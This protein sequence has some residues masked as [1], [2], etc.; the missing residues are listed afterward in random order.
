[1]LNDIIPIIDSIPHQVYV[2]PFGGSGVVILNKA[3]INGIEVLNDIDDNIVNF[4]RVMRDDDSRARLLQL[5]EYTPYAKNEFEACINSAD[6]D[7]V[8]RAR[9]Y[10]VR[11]RQSYA[12]IGGTWGRET[13]VKDINRSLSRS[14][15]GAQ[16][17]IRVTADRFRHIQVECQDWELVLD[18][19][20]A[21]N[22]LY[23]LDPPYA[24]STRSS[25]ADYDHELSSD[26]HRR[27]L[28]R[29][30]TLQA[31]WVL[32][33]YDDRDIYNVLNR[34]DIEHKIITS[35]AALATPATDGSRPPTEEH[36]WIRRN[37]YA[38]RE[39]PVPLF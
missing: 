17:L 6:P 4:F 8:E 20:D 12:G 22:A 37:A 9:N 23:Y 29:L 15:I 18:D 28:A 27:L 13:H 39:E 21:E 35:T 33:G 30:L 10:F 38:V 14:F 16:E 32:S 1:M 5:L 36:I 3:P 11:L 19:Y 34:D 24:P 2:E 31:S 26:D 25:N 7:P